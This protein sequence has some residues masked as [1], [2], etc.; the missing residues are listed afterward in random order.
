MSAT[1]AKPDRR[2]VRTKQLLYRALMELIKEKG[3]ANVTVTDLTNRAEVNRG[4]FYLHYRDVP[5]MLEQLKDEV[6]ESIRGCVVKLSIPQAM[7]H[8]DRN[9]VYPAS[10]RIFEEFARHA[11]FLQLMFGAKGD[12][13]FALRFRKLIESHITSQIDLKHI[14]APIDYILAYMASANFGLIMHWLE[15][16]RNQTPEQMSKLL[17]RIINFGPMVA[18]GI[19]DFPAPRN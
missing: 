14:Q 7:K 10:I 17:M 2:Q 5:D 15:S 1:P 16:G 11:D 4:T 6:F 8:A 12:L 9:E 3:A 18:F 19:R 13:S